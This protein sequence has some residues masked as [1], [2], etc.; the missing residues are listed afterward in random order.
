ML[1]NVV[2]AGVE[3]IHILVIFCNI[4]ILDIDRS[5]KEVQVFQAVANMSRLAEVEGC[6][7]AGIKYR[8]LY[9]ST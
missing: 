4:V 1:G 5:N 7:A 2:Q 3:L 9:F 8:H 6:A